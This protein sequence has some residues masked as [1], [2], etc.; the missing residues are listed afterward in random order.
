[1]K[2]FKNKIKNRKI[3]S[4][5]SVS[6]FFLF[7]SFG[8]SFA[9][10]GGNIT[11]WAWG[12][13]DSDH[14]G[15]YTPNIDG[16]IG[17]LSFSCD[18]IATQCT[19]SNYGI[20]LDASTGLLSGYAR[21]TNM[22][23]VTFNASDLADCP[24]AMTSGVPCAAHVDL[25]GGAVTGWARSCSVFLMGCS[26]T[27]SQNNGAWDGWI[28]LSGINHTSPGFANQST[29]GVTFDLATNSFFGFAW[30]GNDSNG[31]NNIG[32]ISFGGYDQADC[33]A[34]V[35]HC[36]PQGDVYVG[37]SIGTLS[38]TVTIP[39]G[40]ATTI[41]W[42]PSNHDISCSTKTYEGPIGATVDTGTNQWDHLV[43]QPTDM[44][45]I[46]AGA[47]GM[48]T[49]TITNPSSTAIFEIR[50]E[51]TCAN[52]IGLTSTG[53]AT[54]F[55]LQNN[56]SNDGIP[57]ATI[58]A[59]NV[60]PIYSP[61]AYSAPS[62]PLAFAASVPTPTAANHA[63]A[64]KCMLTSNGTITHSGPGWTNISG[65]SSYS[66]SSIDPAITVQYSAPVDSYSVPNIDPLDIPAGS[67]G[68]IGGTPVTF[69][70]NCTDTDGLTA[71]STVTVVR[72]G[73]NPS[74]LYHIISGSFLV[75]SA[76]A[77]ISPVD[78][79]VKLGW[80]PTDLISCTNNSAPITPW[81]TYPTGSPTWSTPGGDPAQ[82]DMSTSD[83]LLLLPAGVS[84]TFSLKC[85]DILNSPHI[86]PITLSPATAP[87]NPGNPTFEEF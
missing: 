69:T 43:S 44:L 32:W 58:Y 64:T 10:T 73:P 60:A 3:L 79:H 17:W 21:S 66:A 31:T 80:V 15:A 71:T 81:A 72:F 34:S 84:T 67:S 74:L 35:T 87:G 75:P 14:D 20:S 78:G 52:A 49:T 38:P 46:A 45:D 11:G 28:E 40:T 59:N 55:V 33:L 83:P 27:L 37:T 13:V 29:S 7:I 2:L 54:V 12:A 82:Y 18:D 26:G 48:T 19:A 86:Y 30:G 24:D 8:I 41:F 77:T 68:S 76:S 39:S 23:W 61:M 5:L 42:Q 1:M 53:S 70:I 6:L 47:I 4:I 56:P 51:M 22:G 25:L 63:T 16:G 36:P 9:Q 62:F 85:I 65:V 57:V 50:Y